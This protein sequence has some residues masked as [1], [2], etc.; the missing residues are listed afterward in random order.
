MS[1]RNSCFI[2]RQRMIVR[3]VAAALFVA[4]FA[5]HAGATT[6]SHYDVVISGSPTVN[7]TFANGVYSANAD[8]AVLNIGDLEN[9]LAAGSVKVTTGNGSGGDENGDLTIE[10]GFTWAAANALTLDSYHSMFV[11]QAVVNAGPGALTLTNNDGGA[12]GT[13]L[14]GT[15]G[16]ITIWGLTNAL[17]I[18]GQAFTLVGDIHTLANDIAANPGGAYALA[19]SYDAS[20]DGTYGG[21]AIQTTLTGTFE[22][23]GNSIENLGVSGGG[24]HF[25]V[26]LFSD[27]GGNARNIILVA[28]N[29]YNEG[30]EGTTGGLAGT[31]TGIVSG[32]SVSGMIY[33]V[34]T[35]GGLVGTN[36]GT[37]SASS[38]TARVANYKRSSAAVGGL[39]GD[40]SGTIEGSSASGEVSGKS[41]GKHGGSVVGGLVGCSCQGTISNSHA[42]G[43]V[44]GGDDD[45]GLAGYNFDAVIINSYATGK[46]EAV[47]A[48]GGLVGYNDGSGGSTIIEQS[49]ATGDV[50]ESHQTGGLA[51]FNQFGGIVNSYATG[52][53][54]GNVA[55]GGL[56]GNN[57]Y[58]SSIGSSYSAGLV[59]GND[60]ASVGGFIGSFGGP[61]GVVTD[62]YWD[63]RTSKTK[64]GTGGGNYAGITG[65]TTKQLKEGLPTG[66]DPTIWA[67]ANGINHGFPYLIANPP[68]Q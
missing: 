26:G 58:E 67:E 43:S 29:V 65:L 21:S 19:N 20:K 59:K 42:T 11:D 10:A 47:F 37:I 1:E 36:S 27:I 38:S 12:S 60:G 6:A 40:N 46:V 49:F 31:N 56:V 54:E 34:G 62:G 41:G 3:S 32:S 9:A 66:F 5:T 18:N 28:S 35:A 30:Y 16:N 7:M 33:S 55:V 14:Y 51:G 50:S 61:Q 45:G 48:V 53:V 64:N 52:K 22:G 2:V 13:I 63:T 17:S 4:A 8:G 25:S 57:D 15:G 68:P 39:V 23:L 24:R 44:S